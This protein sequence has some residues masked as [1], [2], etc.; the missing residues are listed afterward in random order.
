MALNILVK[1]F[2]TRDNI[3]LYKLQYNIVMKYTL[4]YNVNVGQYC[5]KYIYFGLRD[6]MCS[7]RF[8]ALYVAFHIKSIHIISMHHELLRTRFFIA[9]TE[10]FQITSKIYLRAVA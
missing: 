1:L 10:L 6:V 9:Y 8:K 2:I 3:A 4:Q 5:A 7:A